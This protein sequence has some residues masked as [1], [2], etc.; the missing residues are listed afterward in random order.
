MTGPMT[1][2]MRPT[3][4]DMVSPW[5][6]RSGSQRFG[7]GNDLDQFLGDHRLARAVVE[8]R[9]LADHVAGVARR[10]VHGRHL[11]TVE[12]GGVLQERAQDLPGDVARQ[13]LAEDV[14]GFRLELVGGAA[15]GVRGLGVEHRRNDLLRR[16]NLCDYRAE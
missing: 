2:V 5:L 1:W 16:R 8:Q 11:R 15:E 10:V 3:L 13:E 12:R 6:A 4:F 14:L 7:A 9:L